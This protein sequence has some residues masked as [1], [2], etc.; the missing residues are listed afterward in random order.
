MIFEAFAPAKINLFLHVGPQRPDGFHPICSL[1][2]FADVGDRLTAAPAERFALELEGPF[3]GHAPAGDDNLVVRAARALWDG[4]GGPPLRI[5]LHKTLPAAA[6]LGGGS[7]DAAATLRLVRRALALD[8]DAA[9]LQA[10]AAG[11]GS[12]VPACLDARPVLVEGRGERLSSGP[13]MAPLHAVLARPAVGSATGPVYRAFDEL[14]PTSA[15]PGE[16]RD[17]GLFADRAGGGENTGKRLGPG[18]RR[19][20]RVEGLGP[21]MPSG[22]ESIHAIAAFLASTRNDLE[23]PAVALEPAIGEVLAVLRRSSAVLFARMSGSGSACF[24]LCPDSQ[25]AERLALELRTEHPD[26]WVTDCRLGGP[27]G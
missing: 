16:S 5:A 13:A 19:G 6:G 1:M 10:I 3:A 12:D 25:A 15:H 26:W 8:V 9:R 27:W 22:L 4:E 7:S 11:L 24:G 14:L 18:F 23:A 2:A 21:K 17:P 20:E